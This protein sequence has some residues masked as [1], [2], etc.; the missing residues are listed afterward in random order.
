[1]CLWACRT[2]TSKMLANATSAFS[3][4]A[5]CMTVVQVSHRALKLPVVGVNGRYSAMPSPGDRG[6]RHLKQ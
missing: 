4:I 3:G 6:A 2:V 5:L 1:M